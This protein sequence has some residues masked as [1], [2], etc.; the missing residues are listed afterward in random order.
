M[1]AGASV[2]VEGSVVA[3]ASVVAA[4]AINFQVSVVLV[5]SEV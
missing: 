5:G 4:E 2:V 3:E 1:V